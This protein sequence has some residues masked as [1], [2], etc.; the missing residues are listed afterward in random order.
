VFIHFAKFATSSAWTRAAL[1]GTEIPI[2][3]LADFNATFN[4]V[5]SNWRK[6]SA[7]DSL[8]IYS[9]PPSTWIA[10]ETKKEES[11]KA[12]K[13]SEYSSPSSKPSNKSGTASNTSN[14]ARLSTKDPLFGMVIVPDNLRHGPQL[15]SG[16][17]LCL[18]FAGQGKA[19][20]HGYNC[21]Q[22][23]VTL[24]RA[25]IPDLKAIERWVIATP[26]VDWALGHPKHLTDPPLA[27]TLNPDSLRAAPAPAPVTPVPAPATQALSSEEIFAWAV[28]DADP[29]LPLPAFTSPPLT[30]AAVKR[31]LQGQV[32]NELPSTPTGTRPARAS[33]HAAPRPSPFLP[34]DNEPLPTLLTNDDSDDE[35]DDDNDETHEASRPSLSS[36]TQPRLSKSSKPAFF[37][38]SVMA[39]AWQAQK[40]QSF[41]FLDD[42]DMDNLFRA[43]PSIGHLW[44]EYERVKDIDWSP[45]QEP[46]PNWQTQERIDQHRV[47]M[48]LACLFHYDMDLAAVHRCLGGNHVGAHRN[49]KK[50]LARVK[51]LLPPKL[52]RDLRRVLVDGCPA[53]F[54]TEG[55]AKEFQEMYAY[56]NHPTVTGNLAK[57]MKT[58]NKEDRKDHV[59]TFPAWVAPFIPHLMITPNGFVVKP[60]KN[61]RLVFDAS[62]M[63]H[64][65]SRPFNQFI[66]LA[67][68]PDIVF[69]EAWIQFLVS[70]YNL[71]ITFP[72]LEIYLMDDDVAS[73]FRQL[74][75]NPNIISAKGILIDMFLFIATGLTFGDRSSPPSF[76]P[77]ARTRIAVSTELSAGRHSVPEFPEYLDQVRFMPPTPPGLH[78]TPARADRYNPGAPRQPVGSS[79]FPVTYKMHVD[80]NL[81]AA[82]GVDHMRWAM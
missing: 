54:N 19:C 68:E 9:S 52:Y 18:H 31:I 34:T 17:R 58:M 62:F 49:V 71:R 28:A 32:S 25:S 53:I 47:D 45:L 78:L 21:Q 44:S 72:D 56:G 16:K 20:V 41:G 60:G 67:D 65:L 76:E 10:P 39:K 75:Y 29:P 50:I 3:A 80:D 73:A 69:G 51:R 30:N 15:P 8:S 43:S 63:L 23:H 37:Q 1:E 70:I 79:Q 74:K 57:V 26:N 81:Y 82:A 5:L 46:N 38:K 61:D 6:I 12:A 27:S 35:D 22:V 55:T 64:L 13:T 24:N 4:V 40:E 7:T 2:S 36:S 11:K 14:S 33:T 42:N 77:I 66:D 48:R 59:L